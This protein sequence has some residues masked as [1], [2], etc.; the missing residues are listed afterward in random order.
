MGLTTHIRG[1]VAGHPWRTVGCGLAR[2][3]LASCSRGRLLADALTTESDFV[4]TPESQ[5]AIDLMKRGWAVRTRYA[6]SVI[7]R[8]PRR[9]STI[10]ASERGWRRSMTSG[11]PPPIAGSGG[12]DLLS[13]QCAV[14]G[15]EP[16]ASTR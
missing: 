14:A 8:S 10:P 13:D 5:K 3:W 9:P 16:R 4:G 12:A 2:R 11:R 6:M 1:V 7:V 15:L